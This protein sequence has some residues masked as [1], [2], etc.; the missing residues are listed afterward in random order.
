MNLKQLLAII[1]G[2]SLI[3]VLL[4]C[5]A[6]TSTPQASNTPVPD[7]TPVAAVEPTP[8][9]GESPAT[10][11]AY[12][13]ND[14]GLNLLVAVNGDVLLRR[15]KWND[16]HP[17]AFGVS[18]Q[19]GDLLRVQG[20]AQATILCD[21]LN[22]WTVPAG[23][24]PSGL[25]GCPRPEEPFLVRQGGRIISTRGGDPTVPYI[26]SPR[27]TKLFSNTPTLRWN[28]TGSASYIVTIRGGDFNWSQ[29][30]VTGTALIYPGQPALEPGVS[31]LLVVEDE[32]GKSSQDEGR[33]GLGFEVLVDSEAQPVQTSVERIT[34]LGLSDEAET[35]ALAQ[36][37]AGHGLI[38][39]A[40]EILETLA[41]TGS[42]QAAVHQALADLYTQTGLV[43][44][45]EPVYLQALA[46]AEQQNNPE[47]LAAIHAALGEKTYIALG[48]A[49]KAVS[50]LKA[51]KA[52][53][54]T[55]GDTDRVTEIEDLIK[56]L[57]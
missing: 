44:L 49:D 10:E 37:Y 4:G 51:A 13:E 46:L 31:Y 18:L 25:N 47:T 6:D 41:E 2:S 53:Y 5:S 30:G 24:A 52:I 27:S 38:T 14:P 12:D 48:N 15:T 1:F 33:K 54:E 29:E 16:F 32:N 35:L 26:I 7:N 40:V 23:A 11:I 42:Q 45:A 43:L 28:D 56:S 39:E 34:E 17:T 22:T 9:A 19:R 8:T 36:F 55:L 57:E 20:G 3:I 21:N 50:H